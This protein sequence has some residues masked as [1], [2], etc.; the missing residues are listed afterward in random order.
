MKMED[1]SLDFDEAAIT[2]T[3]AFDDGWD[4]ERT[5]AENAWEVGFEEGEQIALDEQAKDEPFWDDDEK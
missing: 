1:K 2:H 3:D 5:D 4:D